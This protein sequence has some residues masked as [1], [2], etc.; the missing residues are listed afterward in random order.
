MKFYAIVGKTA[1]WALIFAILGCWGANA[2]PVE[3]APVETAS[4]ELSESADGIPDTITATDRAAE[5]LEVGILTS[6]GNL[7]TLTTATDTDK[8]GASVANLS[9]PETIQAQVLPEGDDS[10]LEQSQTNLLESDSPDDSMDQVT[11][12]SQ[13]RDVSPGDWAYEALRSL[14]ERYGCIAGYPDGTFRGNRAMT[15]YEFA[16]GLNAC[17]Q[18][19]ERFL[20]G[21]Q[22]NVPQ[23][24]LESLQRLIREFEGELATLGARVDNLEG[25]VSFLEDHQ[26][27]TTT[28]LFGQAIIGV[29]GHSKNDFNLVGAPVIV[30]NQTDDNINV[31]NNVQLSLFTQLSPR[32]LLLTSLQAGKG[33]TSNFPDT[34]GNYIRLGYEGDNNNDVRVT[35][36]NFRHLFGSKLALIV[37]PEGVSPVNVF[38]GVNRIESSGSGPLSSFAQRN[39]IIGV[40]NGSGGIGFDWQIGTRMSL[41]GVY[42]AG[43][44]EDPNTGIFGGDNG[45]T[46][47][48]LQFVV[49]PTDKIDISLQ[50]IN[51]Y[52]PFGRLGTGVGDDLVALAGAS[53]RAP[54]N[55]N[56]VG[57]GLEWRVTPR[58]TFGGWAGYTNSD[59]KSDSGNVETF[60]WMAFLNIYDLLGEGN[61]AGLYIG[62]PPRITSSDL[63]NGR[64][65]PSFITE[66]NFLAS[67]G[68]QPDTTTHLELF[69]RFKV[70]ENIS[71]TP[72]VIVILNPLQNDDNDTITIGAIRTTFSF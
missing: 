46:S 64:N 22:P 5:K 41:Q 31:I 53:G 42:S 8:S 58:F 12:V 54:I 15:R 70:S 34:L 39:P 14:V 23:G 52:S 32:S 25:R 27:S 26:F 16:A 10:S 2:S 60:N 59:L 11:N 35:D 49:S 50:Y 65:V 9:L 19:V 21:N 18:Q 51:A 72:G 62:Q 30:G 20:A 33:S 56:A 44:P 45:T 37:G 17:L 3:A 40:G 36:L 29:Q 55:T 48:G 47:A 69:Y 6:Q 4:E 67:E 57:A 66:G 68:A 24:D 61:L 7:T 13:L 38:R 43:T 28:K 71:I 63:P 1:Y